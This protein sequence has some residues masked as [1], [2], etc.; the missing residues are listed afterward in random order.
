MPVFT[1][2]CG[3]RNSGLV[4]DIF[5]GGRQVG[6]EIRLP[7]LALFSLSSDSEWNGKLDVSLGPADV[8][9]RREAFARGRLTEGGEGSVFLGMGGAN[10][11]D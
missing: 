6:G 5:L 9:G 2:V 1:G 10:A 8:W 7:G 11:L 3:S 4:G